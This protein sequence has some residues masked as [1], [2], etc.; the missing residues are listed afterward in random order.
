MAAAMQLFSLLAP[1][2]MLACALAVRPELIR[3]RIRDLMAPIG[4]TAILAAVWLAVSATELGQVN[5][6]AGE[7]TDNRLFDEIRGPAIGQLYDLVLFVIA[8][9][10]LWKLAARWTPEVRAAS[11]GVISRDRDV[12]AVTIGWAVV[13]TVIL[14][15]ASFVHPIYSV[16]YVTASA[17]GLALLVSFVCVRVFPTTLDRAR[18]SD[19]VPRKPPNRA[20]QAFCAVAVV[21]LVVGYVAAASALQEDLKT[22][23]DYVAQ[24][25]AKGDVFAVPD[26][27]MTGAVDYYTANDGRPIPLWPQ[28][29]VR[30][31]FVEG[32]DLSLHPSTDLPRRVWL[33]SDGSVP[34]VHFQTV[35]EQLGYRL[36][37]IKRFNGSA[38]LLYDSTPVSVV[39]LP[40]SGSTLS[41]KAA[42]LLAAR[43]DGWVH[44]DERVQ[45]VLK[46]GS[47]SE[48]VIGTGTLSPYGWF[49]EWDTTQTPNGTYRLQSAVTN[50]MG[51]TLYSSPVIVKVRN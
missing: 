23:A 49:M 8:A 44:L 34:V 7:S 11:V 36:Q 39:V 5:W 3:Q 19:R 2:S 24:H 10:V 31:P 17:P 20:L 43:R 35:L 6:I 47:S 30:Q 4:L 45:F 14:A 18:L 46:S 40:S 38:L 15:L 12:L 27:A 51:N 9:F 22:P 13:P 25:M 33:L 48:R 41:G 1:A 28:L 50:T 16:R 29:G 42:L 37:D 32:L 26:H 21:A